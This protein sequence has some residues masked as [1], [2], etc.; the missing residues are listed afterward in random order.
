[1]GLPIEEI[2]QEYR[3]YTKEKARLFD[4]SFIREFCVTG[5]AKF[6][7]SLRVLQ[8]IDE[9]ECRPLIKAK[10]TR[11]VWGGIIVR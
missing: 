4:E 9:I 11:R 1:V 7:I 10:S 2:L 6:A 8:S 3:L 5:L